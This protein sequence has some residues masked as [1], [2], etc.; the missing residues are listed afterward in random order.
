MDSMEAMEAE[1]V[2]NV[3]SP[4]KDELSLSKLP[5]A[6]KVSSSAAALRHAGEVIPNLWVGNI[7]SVSLIEELI[8]MSTERCAR[9]L[10]NRKQDRTKQRAAVTLTVISVISNPNLLKFV[11][12]S[13][14]E[15]RKYFLHQQQLHNE[16]KADTTTNGERDGLE[17]DASA[18]EKKAEQCETVRSRRSGAIDSTITSS[19][20]NFVRTEANKTAD[21][22]V[23]D[24]FDIHI[25]HI[26][27]PLRD[28]LDSDLMSILR[29]SLA[30]IDEALGVCHDSINGQCGN[31]FVDG[32]ISVE[33]DFRICLVHCAKGCSRSAECYAKC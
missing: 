11:A 5:C 24:F 29:E 7:R 32:K 1:P 4:R 22:R 2:T 25:R 31:R 6:P 12:D 33:D 13:L 23:S 16:Q 3:G 19:E 15:R 9:H 21:L 10:E 20:N 18:V 14:D 8:R 27:V 30:T 26:E 28:S 17:C